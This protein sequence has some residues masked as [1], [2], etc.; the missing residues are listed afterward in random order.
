MS[1]SDRTLVTVDV[2]SSGTPLPSDWPLVSVDVRSEVDRLPVATLQYLDGDTAR[3]EFELSD[4]PLLNLG[5]E[6]E[7][8]ARWEDESA[9]TLFKGI[10]VRHGIEG[11]PEG[12]RLVVE[13]VH[14]AFRMTLTRKSAVFAEMSDA[15]VVKRLCQ[16]A[17]L[18]C[19]M[20][21][22]P[23][24]HRMLAQ[25][26]CTDWD[27]VL[28]RLRA[29]GCLLALSPR[30]LKAVDSVR[31]GGQAKTVLEFGNDLLEFEFEGDL[32]GQLSNVDAIGWDPKKQAT[33]KQRGKD[34]DAPLGDWKPASVVKSAAGGA[35]AGTLVHPGVNVEAELGRWA[36]AR[37]LRQRLAFVRG[38]ARCIG[39]GNMALLDTVEFK[40]TGKHFSGKALVTGVRH[41]IES[42]AWTTDIQV[43]LSSHE[44]SDAAT[45]GVADAPA[46]GLIP[47]AGGLQIG[48]VSGFAQD[49][50]K[51]L[52]L[53]VK[54][55]VLGDAVEL[56][57]R[58]ATPDAG[59][60]RGYYFRPETGDEVVVGFLNND[61]RAPIVMGSLF[62]PKHVPPKAFGQPEQDNEKKGLVSRQGSVVGFLDAKKPSVWIETPA[63]NRLTLDD[64]K[65]SIVIKDQHGNVIT[66]DK[67][68]IKLDSAADV[69]I[70]GKGNIKIS[71]DGTMELKGAKVD[72][73]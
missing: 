2:L 12:T 36:G 59:N 63:H 43:G 52:R 51:A 11:R 44:Q 13:A 53:K 19:A 68:G 73:K 58:L 4:S 47:P 18:Q 28:S 39:A 26:H 41:Y 69:V 32:S 9:Q 70:S 37:L 62:G 7:I 20:P 38:R 48:I 34:G 10:V 61:P 65:Q 50:D 24:K 1:P 71:A 57:A 35:S 6:I 60:E 8:R 17:G 25:F 42:G 33:V 3:A 30:G 15:D 46:A 21:Q 16:G 67:A 72:V 14:A 23:L 31:P 55:P 56:W 49:A 45:D 22:T 40:G 64:D 29:A 66:L 5:R 54:L 27:F